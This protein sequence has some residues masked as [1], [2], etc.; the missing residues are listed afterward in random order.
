M[1]AQAWEESSSWISGA[2]YIW[3]QSETGD[4]RTDP[5]VCQAGSW[6]GW[7]GSGCWQSYGIY[8]EMPLTWDIWPEVRD[9]TGF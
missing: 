5:S 1:K 8:Q 7:T 4:W 2:W 9:S 3:S 6:G